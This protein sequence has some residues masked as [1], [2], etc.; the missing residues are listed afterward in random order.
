MGNLLTGSA[1]YRRYFQE[2][3]EANEQA[4]A[5]DREILRQISQFISNQE[6]QRLEDWLEGQIRSLETVGPI[7]H[8]QSLFN[9]GMTRGLRIVQERIRHQRQQVKEGNP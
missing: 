1:L 9:A 2:P 8:G 7:E 6:C 3:Q 5:E 4:E